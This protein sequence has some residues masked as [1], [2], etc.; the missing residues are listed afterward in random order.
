MRLQIDLEFSQN[1][2]KEVKKKIL[3]WKC[4]IHNLE[5]EKLLLRNKKFDNLERFH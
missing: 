5:E 4:F 3:T 2:K 1:K